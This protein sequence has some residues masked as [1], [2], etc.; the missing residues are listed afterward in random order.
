RLRRGG[1]AVSRRAGVRPPRAPS[2]RPAFPASYFAL[3][4]HDPH[5]VAAVR[6]FEQD[7]DALLHRRGDVLADVVRPDRQLPV[8]A[9]DEDSELYAGGPTEVGK[10]IHRGADAP[11]GVE[12]GVYEH[13][14]PAVDVDRHLGPVTARPSVQGGD[15][16][17]IE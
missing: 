17:G 1:D 2:G 13:H 9:I 11:A 7:L 12:H 10:R 4:P 8:T 6:L 3:H 15:V 5:L 14:A 16:A